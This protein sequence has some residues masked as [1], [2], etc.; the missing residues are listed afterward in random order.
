MQ[1]QQYLTYLKE[2]LTEDP[3]PFT[4]SPAKSNKTETRRGKDLNVGKNVL[5]ESNRPLKKRKEA[6]NGLQH[7]LTEIKK[8]VGKE[9]EGNE[10][11]VNEEK[12]TEGKISGNKK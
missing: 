4:P 5:M 12:S 10:G 3:V 11:K 7:S 2:I 1:T 9:H 8:K 6:K